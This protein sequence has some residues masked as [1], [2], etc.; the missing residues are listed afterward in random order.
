MQVI[1]EIFPLKSTW[2]LQK[3]VGYCPCRCIILVRVCVTG[4]GLQN[5]VGGH[6]PPHVYSYT[7]DQKV[8][9]QV[10]AYRAKCGNAAA[11]D[12]K[13]GGGSRSLPLLPVFIS[14]H[15]SSH[16]SPLVAVKCWSIFYLHLCLFLHL[17]LW[18]PFF[19]PF[20]FLTANVFSTLNL[21][22]SGY[23]TNLDLQH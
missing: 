8:H 3:I 20:L 17:G 22:L 23:R 7:S 18:S 5:V 19:L 16:H 1:N 15:L 9:E 6:R 21:S 2:R 11:D 10:G 13:Y 12:M 4:K 14:I